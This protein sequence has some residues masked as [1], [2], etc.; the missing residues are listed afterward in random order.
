[1]EV[2]YSRRN[3]FVVPLVFFG[4]VS[5]K[6]VIYTYIFMIVAFGLILRCDEKSVEYDDICLVF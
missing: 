3:V 2:E 4:Q 5:F 1:M 6:L